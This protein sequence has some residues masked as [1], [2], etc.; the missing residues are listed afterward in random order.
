[1]LELTKWERLSGR[2]SKR[3]VAEHTFDFAC[4]VSNPNRLT[5]RHLPTGRRRAE[6]A[7]WAPEGESRAQQ[8][9]ICATFRPTKTSVEFVEIG[10]IQNQAFLPPSGDYTSTG[11]EKCKTN[12]DRKG[13][14]LAEQT[15]NQIQ[16]YS[17]NEIALVSNLWAR[18]KKNTPS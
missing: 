1:M 9:E 11:A 3:L 14:L 16:Y 4:G 5:F 13:K 2:S 7:L 17:K 15:G 10:V 12:T 8:I 6:A 18:R